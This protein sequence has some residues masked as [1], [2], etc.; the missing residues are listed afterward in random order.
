MHNCL[1]N[2]GLVLSISLLT[3]CAAPKALD[4]SPA[5]GLTARIRALPMM[6]K[7][8]IY[9]YPGKTCYTPKEKPE[10]IAHTGGKDYSVINPLFFFGANKKVGMPPTDDMPWRYHEFIVSADQPLTI[11]AYYRRQGEIN[12]Q[13]RSSNCGPIVGRYI[14]N[15]GKDYDAALVFER[16]RCYLRV[17]E[18]I[19]DTLTGKVK[20]TEIPLTPASQC[21]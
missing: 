13:F 12:G 19:P 11:M 16:G 3:S 14:P 5:S 21:K 10:I 9:L 15:S 17:R 6:D 7:A 20:P 4:V 8:Y 18:L 2:A 1:F